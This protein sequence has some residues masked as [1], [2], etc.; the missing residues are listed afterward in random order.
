MPRRRATYRAPDAPF[1]VQL[2][3]VLG[4]TLLGLTIAALILL[5][6]R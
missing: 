6:A 5:A 2:A 4:L 1:V 3:L